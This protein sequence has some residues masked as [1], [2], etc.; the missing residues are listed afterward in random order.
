MKER[1]PLRI[2]DCD[3][4]YDVAR[5]LP[6]KREFFD[7]LEVIT[8]EGLHYIAWFTGQVWDGLRMP[9]GSVIVRWKK[10]KELL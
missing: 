5:H 8:D 9:E 2:K 7:L 6:R 10:K 3:D 4:Y 1:E